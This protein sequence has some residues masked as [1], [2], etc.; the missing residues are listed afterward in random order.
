MELP[1][2]SENLEDLKSTHTP[3]AIQERLQEGNKHNYLRD[4]VYGAMDGAVTTFAVVSSVAGAGLQPAI[5]LIMGFA[6]LIAD[7]FSMAVGNYVAT[8]SE[9][10][11]RDKARRLEEQ[12]IEKYPEGEKEEVR[13]IF[14][15]KGFSGA[16]LERAVEIITADR[17]QWIDTMLQEE[18]GLTLDEPSPFKAALAT[19]ASFFLIGLLPLV[20]FIVEWIFPGFVK[21][22][23]SASSLI[24][25]AAFFAVGSLK[26]RYVGKAWY[27]SGLETFSIG[28]MAALLAYGMGLFLKN[29]INP[30]LLG[31]S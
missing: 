19:F 29:L 1:G 15:R 7:G 8:R 22:P 10:E 28:A 4:M 14:R 26:G 9:Y 2:S 13:Q 12:H 17:K 21:H 18:L 5:V 20:S 25:C 3:E 6:N 30:A 27:R 11:L 16:E 24:T 31:S 23:F